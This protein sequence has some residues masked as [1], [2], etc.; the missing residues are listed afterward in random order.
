MNINGIIQNY[1]LVQT[2]SEF[3]YSSLL[4]HSLNMFAAGEKQREYALFHM[5]DFTNLFKTF[6]KSFE[7]TQ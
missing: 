3:L 4:T 5:S 7:L 1:L 2:S 6:E